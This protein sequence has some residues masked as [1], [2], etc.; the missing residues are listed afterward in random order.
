MIALKQEN[1]TFTN[2]SNNI[3]TEKI[4]THTEQNDEDENPRNWRSELEDSLLT[5]PRVFEPE[6]SKTLGTGKSGKERE[7][8]RIDSL[9]VRVA[10][11]YGIGAFLCGVDGDIVVLMDFD[12]CVVFNPCLIICLSA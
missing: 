8:T 7:R 11:G 10:R 12:S 1:H 6:T 4:N 3:R 2:Q 5:F 9:R